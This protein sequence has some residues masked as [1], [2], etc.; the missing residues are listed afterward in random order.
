MG[1]S[2]SNPKEFKKFING[3]IR[4]AFDRNEVFQGENIS[5]K[6]SVKLSKR[7]PSKSLLIKVFG[8]ETTVICN[9]KKYDQTLISKKF[10]LGEQKVIYE[11]N[12]AFSLPG[13]KFFE[14]K[15]YTF[16][17]SFPIPKNIPAS[18][19]HFCQIKDTVFSSEIQFSIF[20]KLESPHDVQNPRWSFKP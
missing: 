4:I 17:F 10:R 3:E 8:T 13:N 12:R 18:F 9:K 14:A 11:I 5:G 20:A 2:S 19:K 1:T 15:N 7:F 6:C 16:N